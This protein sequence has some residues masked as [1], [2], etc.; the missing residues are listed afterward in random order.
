M[1]FDTETFGQRCGWWDRG[2]FAQRGSLRCVRV[3]AVVGGHELFGLHTKGLQSKGLQT[4]GLHSPG[5]WSAAAASPRLRGFREAIGRTLRLRAGGHSGWDRPGEQPTLALFLLRRGGPRRI[6]NERALAANGPAGLQ[7]HLT[8]DPS[9]SPN[10]IQVQPHT[11]RAIRPGY[12]PWLPAL[13]TALA[14]Y[15][16]RSS[17][18]RV[19]SCSSS[20]VW[21]PSASSRRSRWSA[22]PVYSSATT[23]QARA[24]WPA[25]ALAA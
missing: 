20:L 17:R 7:A 2:S 11:L 18:A 14:A 10:P 9:P 24:R 8:P 13:T 25:I 15:S 4:K 22:A 1:G 16:R 19:G 12:L 3:G 6:L 5:L 21:R 23:A